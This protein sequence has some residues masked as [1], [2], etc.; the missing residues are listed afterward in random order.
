MLA[1]ARARHEQVLG[2]RRRQREH[3]S[4][5]A[6]TARAASSSGG[7]RQRG[8]A[9]PSSSSRRAAWATARRA[10]TASYLAGGAGGRRGSGDLRACGGPSLRSAHHGRRRR[11]S[12]GAVDLR[13][14]GVITRRLVPSSRP[15]SCGA[16]AASWSRRRRGPWSTSRDWRAHSTPSPRS[17]TGSES[18]SKLVAED[19]FAVMAR[20][21]RINGAPKL[22]APHEGRRRRAAQPPGARVRRSAARQAQIPLPED[23]SPGGAR[24]TSTAG[25]PGITVEL[26]GF[27]FHNSRAAWERDQR[28]AREAYARGDEFRPH[29]HGTTST[30]RRRSS[31]GELG[32]RCSRG[33][34]GR[35]GGR[36][37]TSIRHDPSRQQLGEARGV[38][39]LRR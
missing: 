13:L 2:R 34:R 7:G 19:V 4:T 27:R 39:V 25:R 36:Y 22:R 1:E 32:T 37:A 6:R 16:I 14:R 26:L 12:P 9:A 10:R 35:A 11:R 24:S 8:P 17:A 29:L 23:E 33:D 20:R 3:C 21:G 38:D 15:A 18:G 5:A 28:R 30:R 31:S